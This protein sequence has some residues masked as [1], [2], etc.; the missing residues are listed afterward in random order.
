MKIPLTDCFFLVLLKLKPS[1][2]IE[3]NIP[4][5]IIFLLLNEMN[6]SFETIK[7]FFCDGYIPASYDQ[8]YKNHMNDH[9]RAFVNIEFVFKISLLGVNDFDS[10]NV[11]QDFKFITKSNIN[12]TEPT[13]KQTS[14]S[15]HKNEFNQKVS[16]S[17]RITKPDDAKYEPIKVEVN[18]KDFLCYSILCDVIVLT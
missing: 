4:F 1:Q 10:L 18:S 12:Q 8:V 13:E 6:K 2:I 15:D 7:C 11:D 9:H 17:V 5:W 16:N 3:C 14:I